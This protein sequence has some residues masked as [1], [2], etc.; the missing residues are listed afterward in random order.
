MENTK[1]IN[2]TSQLRQNIVTG[3]WVI[4]ATSRGKRPD[5]FV[6]KDNSEQKNSDVYDPFESPRESGQ[7]ADVL[8]YRDNGGEW[9]TRVFPNKYPIVT[10]VDEVEV[11][12]EG[13]HVGVSGYGAHELV[14]TRDA[15]KYFAK[16]DVPAIAEVIDAFQDRYLTHMRSR[17]VRYISIFHNHGLRAGA[18]IAHP[19]SQILA[20]PVVPLV[21]QAEID[22]TRQ[23]YRKNKISPFQVMLEHELSVR[24]R[25][26]AENDDFV[27]LCPFASRA[28]MEM[29]IMP[30]DMQP[31]FERITDAKKVALAEVLQAALKA[32]DRGLNNPDLN[33][34]IHTAP[35]DGWDH[36]Q[37]TW[38]I[39]IVPR[40]ERI[41]GFELATSMEV[42]TVAPE[43]AAVFLRSQL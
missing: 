38:Y 11:T 3:E 12:E 43:D 25:L 33:F 21:V 20:L 24:S 36:A 39:D 13:P 14:V 22:A 19:H 10:T 28:T 34:F 32:L 16:M 31:Y 30:K 23:F 17:A 6:R 5:D 7:E 15:E 29:Y 8:I 1:K 40:T 42:V 2:E 37:Y 18:S 27:V 41:A 26:V 35:C 4:V 9:T